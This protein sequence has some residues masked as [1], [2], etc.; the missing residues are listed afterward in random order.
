MQPKEA[1][2]QRALAEVRDGMLVG[3]GTGSTAAFFIDGLGRLVAAGLSI[4]AVATSRASATRA[5]GLGIPLVEVADRPIDLTVDGADEID[6]RLNLVKGLGGALL[7]EKVVASASTRMIVI[8]TDDKLVARLGRGPLPVEILP[9]L[10]THTNERLAR[11]GLVP[12]LREVDG[13]PFVSDNGGYVVDCRFTP[14]PDLAR[15]A[16]DIAAIPGV[17]GHG[18]FLGIATEA[19][20]AGPG[21]VRVVRPQG[22]SS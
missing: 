20:V 22:E 19:M 18:L 6:P 14:P 15:L 8:A 16:A 17:L 9:L 10:W 5:A 11:L 21:G 1:A 7:R 3:L 12:T 13:A 4:T 2:A